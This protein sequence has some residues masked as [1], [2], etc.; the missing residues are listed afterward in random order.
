[1]NNF[2]ANKLTTI[3]MLIGM[4]V[5]LTRFLSIETPYVRLGFGFIPI[6]IIAFL[7]GGL[8]AGTSYAIADLIGIFLFP[9]RVFFIGFTIS[10]LLI[11]VI[12]GK[13]L[14]CKTITMFN[15]ILCSLIVTIGIHLFLNT[16]W[17]TILLGKGWYGMLPG[18]LFKSI[19]MIPVQTFF[20]MWLSKFSLLKNYI[21]Y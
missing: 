10:A 21:K 2:S 5:I 13:F 12:Y 16:Y 6:M 8:A 17:L 9:K 1:M 3:S 11:G 4:E 7:Y 14:K 20:I 18:R 15:A 19:L